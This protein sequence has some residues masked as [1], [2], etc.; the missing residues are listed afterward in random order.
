MASVLRHVFCYCCGPRA[1][2]PGDGD[3]V[4]EHT[5]FIRPQSSSEEPSTSNYAVNHQVLKDRLGTIVR[6]KENKMVN[7]S[8]DLPFNLANKVLHGQI[9]DLES[10]SSPSRSR[11]AHAILSGG[12][13][14]SS[15]LGGR[16][17]PSF[18]HSQSPPPRAGRDPSPSI[19][20]SRSNSSLH[21]GDASYLPPEADPMNG[22][23]GPVLNARLVRRPGTGGFG[24][25]GSAGALRQGRT[26]T[27]GRLGRFESE[28]GNGI[29]EGNG[30]SNG[31]GLVI[32]VDTGTGTEGGIHE[33]GG[34]DDNVRTPRASDSQAIPEKAIPDFGAIQ[35]V[36]NIT[37]SWG[38]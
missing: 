32:H 22:V 26:I 6:A 19:Q 15:V 38:D 11:S 21:P 35:D 3:D 23:R 34:A 12:V 2:S 8:T 10:S 9:G 13:A 28:A 27:R 16:R 18:S 4:N 7:V 1:H 31:N 30:Q 5:P 25:G 14:G 20:T 37:C 24:V 17:A 33:N 29:P 36:G